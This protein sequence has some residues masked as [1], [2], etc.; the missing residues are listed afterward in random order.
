[1]CPNNNVSHS[2]KPLPLPVATDRTPH[3]KVQSY[4]LASPTLQLRWVGVAVICEVHRGNCGVSPKELHTDIP[5]RVPLRV[6]VR[7]VEICVAGVPRDI[8]GDVC[9][10]FVAGPAR[11]RCA[12]VRRGAC[13]NMCVAW[14]RGTCEEMCIAGRRGTCKEKCIA[15]RAGVCEERCITLRH[16]ACAQ[17]GVAGAT[18]G[19]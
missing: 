3:N 13:Q 16:L 6:A 11:K 18:R 5:F 10:G 1:M 15:G 14:R 19:L 8:R 2:N 4:I 12:A 17:M 7:R 9:R